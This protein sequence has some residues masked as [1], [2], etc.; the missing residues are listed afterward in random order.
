MFNLDP[1]YQSCRQSFEGVWQFA[2]EY[3]T[4]FTGIC[5]NPFSNITA[6]QRPGINFAIENQRFYMSYIVA[7]NMG[8]DQNFLR[9]SC[10]VDR[11]DQVLL[12][13][14][15]RTASCSE[16]KNAKLGYEQL[17]L[18]HVKSETVIPKCSFPAT[19]AG[20]WYNT[21]NY[22]STVIINRTHIHEISQPDQSAPEDLYYVCQESRDTRFLIAK[23]GI[24]GC[25]LDYMC[26]DILERHHNVIQFRQGRLFPNSDFRA[27]CAWSAFDNDA[28]WRY[29]ILVN[30]NPVAVPCSI[31]GIFEFEQYGNSKLIVR[32]GV[33][34]TPW[35]P[36]INCT[37]WH[38]ELR[39][40]PNAPDTMMININKCKTLDY[41]AREVNFKYEIV[42]YKW[43]CLA[44]WNE[45]TLAMMYT[46]DKDDAYSKYRC[47]VILR[48]SYGQ[49][50]LSRSH[51]SACGRFQTERA[52]S[53]G[54]SL[55]LVL[56]DSERIY[57]NCPVHYYDGTNP[58]KDQLFLTVLQAGV[59]AHT[60]NAWALILLLII[61]Y[62]LVSDTN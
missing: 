26:F 7:V 49:F 50:T 47:W 58:R 40:C 25:Q 12:M 11:T 37:S 20:T 24:G 52:D 59:V 5:D 28:H 48:D 62:A 51:R 18:T 21:A 15:S 14:K 32:D 13:T 53:D 9:F 17:K 8:E 43:R 10:F 33:T 27:V 38:T 34:K 60:G 45:D 55:Q 2:Y 30:A 19:L 41:R 3:E 31:R 1:T 4:Q 29:S 23:L 35:D 44:Y 46:Y 22:D 39:I 54:V 56:R 6:C 61:S 42:D 57:D 16:L 36:E